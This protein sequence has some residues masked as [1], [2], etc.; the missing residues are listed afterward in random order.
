[1]V[2][3]VARASG[4]HH[5]AGRCRKEVTAPGHR[6]TNPPAQELTADVRLYLSRRFVIRM[7]GSCGMQEAFRHSESAQ[8]YHRACETWHSAFWKWVDQET[9]ADSVRALQIDWSR[10]PNAEGDV[11]IFRRASDGAELSR[12][13]WKAWASR[14]GISWEQLPCPAAERKRFMLEVWRQ[15]YL[16]EAAAYYYLRRSPEGADPETHKLFS[17][18]L[19]TAPK[20]GDGSY[21][22]ALAEHKQRKP[23]RAVQEGLP[24]GDD[25]RLRE[26]LL[27]WWI[28]GCFWAS[29]T[30]GI[31][32]FLNARY[33]RSKGK[34][35]N[36]KTVSDAWRDLK[37]YRLRRPLWWGMA[38]QPPR[39]ISLR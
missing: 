12:F 13:D 21:F 19:A 27:C 32:A 23:T 25:R 24:Q 16:L 22:K 4:E 11:W 36:P 7:V 8:S 10:I 6:S 37:L 39:L 1:M 9:P 15:E 29:T 26:L 30:D 18:Y 14:R 3:C 35:Y 2:C 20:I 38:G 33:P 5:S 28:P 17:A 31:V 34:L